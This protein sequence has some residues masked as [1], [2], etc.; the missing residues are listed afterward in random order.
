MY[1]RAN[2]S[3]RK[4]QRPA[5]RQYGMLEA[6]MINSKCSIPN[7]GVPCSKPLGGFKVDTPFHPSEVNKMSNR[8]FNEL[9]GEK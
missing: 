5:Q 9:S 1:K 6:F 4:Q 8:F 7:S 2:E 3:I